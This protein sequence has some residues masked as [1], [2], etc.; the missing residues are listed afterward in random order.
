MASIWSRSITRLVRTSTTQ[1]RRHA[2]SSASLQAASE[3]RT[4]SVFD[5]HTVEDLHGMSAA[6]L[7]AEP[8][9]RTDSKMRHFTG[10]FDL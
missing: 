9:S 8:T 10:D 4:K 7:L 5:Y 3:A 6:D 1:M 2:A